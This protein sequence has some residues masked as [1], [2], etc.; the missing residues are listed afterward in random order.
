MPRRKKNLSFEEELQLLES[1]IAQAEDTLKQL[2]K[3]RREILQVKEEEDIKTLYVA[4]K[5]SGKSIADVI[6][7][8]K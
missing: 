1:E 7:T 4:I 5:E 2:K 3:R 6:S 8:L